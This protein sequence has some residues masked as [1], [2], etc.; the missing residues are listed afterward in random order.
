MK[1]SLLLIVTALS[2]VSV[3]VVPAVAKKQHP[4]ARP[5]SAGQ[6]LG[7]SLGYAYE[8]SRARDMPR[9]DAIQTCSTEAAKWRYSDWQSAQLT[10]Y[11]ACMMQHGQPFE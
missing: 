10:N 5:Q 4:A 9:S 3:S 1:A 11:R 2:L 8:P 7:Q 6:S